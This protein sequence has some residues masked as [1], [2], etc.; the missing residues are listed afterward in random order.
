MLHRIFLLILTAFLVLPGQAQVADPLP[1]DSAYTA[2]TLDNGLQYFIRPNSRPE[3]RATLWLAVNAGSILEEEDQLGLAH[4]LEHMAFNGTRDFDKQEMVNYLESVGMRFGPD[5][6]AYTSFDETVYMLEVPTDSVEIMENALLIMENWASGIT[7]SDE[8]IE[9]ERGVVLEE[10]RAGKG[11]GARI[12]D[13]QFPTL[14]RGSKYPD[15]IPI[16]TEEIIQTADAETFR[17]FYERWYRPDNMAV[18]A[19]GDFDPAE[20]EARI[21]AR[22]SSLV[23][24][25]GPLDRPSHPIPPHEETLV[26]VIADPEV[27]STSFVIYHLFPTR[28]TTT[29]ADNRRSFVEA[30]FHGMLN[31]RLGE[32]R[33]EPD[34]PFLFAGS[35]SGSLVRSSDGHVQSAQVKEGRMLDALRAVL[36]EIERVD[37]FGFTQSEIERS[38]ANA[39]R[40]LE[41]ALAEK[42]KRPSRAHAGEAL[43]HFLT[44]SAL[45]GIEFNVAQAR[46][47]I[48]TITIEEVNALARQT[49]S[50]GS[51]VI[52]VT[53]PE[54]ESV[55][56][57]SAEDLLAVFDEVSADTTIT[58]WED[59]VLEEPLVKEKPRLSIVIRET[60]HEEIGVTE[61]ELRNGVRVV[62]KP[63][64]F[65]NDQ[66]LLQG[67]S[68]GGSSLVDDA[69]LASARFATTVLSAGGLGEFDP[70]Q[71][72]KAL[73]GKLAGASVSISSLEESVR[74][75]ASPEDL[76][77][78]LQLTYLH[79]TAPRLDSVRA[80]AALDR[81]REQT[82]NSSLD[83][84]SV[85]SREI[86]K[87][88]NGDHPRYQDT[89][90]EALAKVDLARSL[91]I[92]QD[93]FADASDF[94]F[95]IVGNFEPQKIKPLVMTWLGGLPSTQREETWRDVSAKRPPGVTHL[96]VWKGLE[97]QSR[98]RIDIEGKLNWNRQDTHD[99][100]SLAAAL[101]ITLREELREELGGV[102]GV[103]VS[104][105]ASS[106]PDSTYSFF[107][108]FGCAPENVQELQNAVFAEFERAKREGFSD[109]VITK[110]REGQRR[111]RETALKQNGF[112]A[113]RLVSYYRAASDPVR[114]LAYD[115]LV[116]SVSSERL[117]M[118]AR[119]YLIPEGMLIARLFPE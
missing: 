5:L 98:V 55:E 59:N 66:V 35:G 10:L 32:L 88:L 115:E 44:G 8:E 2:G 15:R 19:A 16:G 26:S 7:L 36:T 85:F 78:L 114:I 106:R 70:V 39:L 111:A 119:R 113:G 58:P 4:F 68:P 23:R 45:P 43:Q 72:G 116:E 87:A 92:Y 41:S 110:V 65:R 102:Y 61:W 109:E 64:D 46:R 79:F 93:R 21:K 25:D 83:P 50:E 3:N 48:P 56:L 28:S 69:N 105:S 60:R 73:T 13:Q 22:F 6:N 77:T 27:P 107:V 47:E 80:E 99:I 31:L 54:K 71:L 74:G 18:I 42:D 103:S 14:L 117:Q 67:F 1:L 24:P 101:R 104:G 112:W 11:A 75:S 63:T 84:G 81:F 29:E 96:N 91:S 95:V 94:T 57:P 9:K 62:M 38:R 37:R 51:R 33:Q 100:Q 89:T 118:A 49:S 17:R 108:G 97:E 34:A 82:R 20:M 86:E 12:R 40:G 30:V 53:G 52:A 76:E 90:E